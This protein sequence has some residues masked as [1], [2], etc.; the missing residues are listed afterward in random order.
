MRGDGR[1]HEV[2]MSTKDNGF[3]EWHD[4]HWLP[5]LEEIGVESNR[6]EIAGGFVS[7]VKKQAD[8]HVH[9]AYTKLDDAVDHLQEAEQ[10]LP[11]AASLPPP[12]PPMVP[13]L[14]LPSTPPPIESQAAA[15]QMTELQA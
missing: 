5:S 9:G 4:K 2:D 13:G 12:A 6:Q 15:R 3:Q 10:Q 7:F 14:A 1:R 11:P 8:G